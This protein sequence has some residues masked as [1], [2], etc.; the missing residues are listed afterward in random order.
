M[1]SIC[2]VC[3]AEATE[4]HHIVAVRDGGTHDYSNL[5]PL[6]KRCHSRVTG[7]AQRG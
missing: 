6:C 1:Y 4:A 5:A 2:E 3:G 7:R